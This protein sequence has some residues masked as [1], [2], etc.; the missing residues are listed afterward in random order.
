MS[1]GRSEMPTTWKDPLASILRWEFKS[2]NS[3][4]D[5]VSAR[6]ERCSISITEWPFYIFSTKIRSEYDCVSSDFYIFLCNYLVGL[7]KML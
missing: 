4:W 6:S 3:C 5:V 1:F 2:G 7:L